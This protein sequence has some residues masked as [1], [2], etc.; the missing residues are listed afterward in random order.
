[1]F[2]SGWWVDSINPKDRNFESTT[3][4]F[5][6]ESIAMKSYRPNLRQVGNGLEQSFDANVVHVE[7]TGEGWL[8]A[9][10][11][12]APREGHPIEMGTPI[13]SLLLRLSEEPEADTVEF[14]DQHNQRVITTELERIELSPTSF[15][16]TFVEGAGP[17]SGRVS[18]S[19]EIEFLKDDDIGGAPMLTSIRVN[20]APAPEKLA[21]LE[22]ALR[23]CES[24]RR[25]LTVM[26]T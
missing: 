23:G 3:D 21:M 19:A 4:A 26:G 6:C 5:A 9:F 14:N 25:I 15:R 12:L 2:W 22:K 11:E 7:D 8:I 20:F 1:M 17:V 16:V 13:H 10:G 24:T 18:L